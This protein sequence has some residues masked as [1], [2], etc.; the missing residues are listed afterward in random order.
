MKTAKNLPPLCAA[1]QPSTGEMILIKRG[2]EGYFPAPVELGSISIDAF[3]QHLGVT[4]V[5]VAAMLAGSMFG[6][7]CPAADPSTYP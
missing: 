4:P 1:V 2:V 3:N 6:W 5:Q 7:D